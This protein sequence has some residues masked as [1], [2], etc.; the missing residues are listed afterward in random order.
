MYVSTQTLLGKK[1]VFQKHKFDINV[2]RMQDYDLMIRISKNN[3]VYFLNEVLVD[4][5]L[6]NNSLT[7]NIR[8]YPK[9]EEVLRYMLKKYEN[10][11]LE[12]PIW[13]AM[14]LKMMIRPIV[15]Q[16][17]NPEFELKEVIKISPT[18]RNKLIL[19]LN[20]IKMLKY[21]YY[22]KKK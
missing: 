5:Y 4:V 19:F 18:S 21:L 2:K 15:M 12:H 7:N 20:K 6:Q 1:E 9:E 11:A 14:I 3:T 13:K 22:I 17:K 8:N 10:I 16:N